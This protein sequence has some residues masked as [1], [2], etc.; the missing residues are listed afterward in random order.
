VPVKASQKL[1]SL[2]KNDLKEQIQSGKYKPGDQ[3]PSES[4]LCQ[5]Y[6]VSRIS[7][8]RALNDL[9]CEGFIKRIPGKG[10]FV[11]EVSINYFVSG[12][13][14]LTSEISKRGMIPGVKVLQFEMMEPAMLPGIAG[15]EFR[16][17]VPTNEGEKVYL[18]KR[19]RLANDEI[20]ALDYLVIRADFY[21]DLAHSDFAINKWLSPEFRKLGIPEPSKA[22]EY[23]CAR[24]VE[25]EEDAEALNVACG[26][27]A[28]CISRIAYRGE[29]ITD[30][31]YR[32]FKGER[33]SY[34]MDLEYSAEE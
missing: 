17:F 29:A 1:H 23:I 12:L 9:E 24:P 32:I 7:A 3:I 11:S 20:I 4:S 26:S 33:F 5:T 8:R 25:A 27:C 18:L 34:C 22:R 10:S 6:Q 30:F 13:Y 28:L 21:P 14:S 19:L 16:K 2:I 31:T 15:N